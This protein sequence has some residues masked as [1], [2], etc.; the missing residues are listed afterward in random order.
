MT[1]G[2]DTFAYDIDDR[3]TSAVIA[4]VPLTFAND[5]FARR[6]AVLSAGTTLTAFA[7][8][9]RGQLTTVTAGD[10]TAVYGYRADGTRGLKAVTT[11]SGTTYTMT[12]W[13]GNHPVA[14]TVAGPGGATSYRYAYDSGGLPLALEVTPSGGSTTLYAYH[15]DALGDVTALTDPAGNVAASY[16]YDPWGRVLA[17]GGSNPA[18]AAAQPLRYRSYYMDAESGLCYLPARYYDPQTARFLS[19]D[20]GPP[21]AGDPASLNR[22]AYCQDDPIGA[23]DPSGAVMTEFYLHDER[24]K[25]GERAVARAQS[26]VA[27]RRRARRSTTAAPCPMGLPSAAAVALMMTKMGEVPPGYGGD[28]ATL[29][30]H[31]DTVLKC[32]L[33]DG[34]FDT[35]VALGQAF[36]EGASEI[37]GIQVRVDPGYAVRIWDPSTGWF[38]SYWLNGNMRTFFPPAAEHFEKLEEASQGELLN[39]ADPA[40]LESFT[41]WCEGAA[42][43]VSEWIE[44]IIG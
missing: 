33:E 31:A 24:A 15:T 23:S 11:S 43:A 3:L 5:D 39:L 29:M 13:S 16:S 37:A 9:A 14:E 36:R 34:D 32:G 7:Y 28:W 26:V 25:I 2:S 30:D 17:A 42:G 44:A 12:L 38:G 19:A 41:N 27:S 22:Y 40:V 18:L 21:S 10:S 1:R 8:N 35:W 6:T 20:P 4:S